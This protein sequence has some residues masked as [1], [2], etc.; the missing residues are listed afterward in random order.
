MY[1]YNS[2]GER[3]IRHHTEAHIRKIEK[4]IPDPS[5]VIC[6]PS[7]GT[8]EKFNKFWNWYRSR[9]PALTYTEQTEIYNKIKGKEQISIYDEIEQP[10]INIYNEIEKKL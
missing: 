7:E 6:Y 2:L 8:T 1:N 3:S 10:E 4:F 5:C 9:F